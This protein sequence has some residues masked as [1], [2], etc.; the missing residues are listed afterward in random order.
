MKKIGFTLAEVLITLGI[1]GVV[2]ALTIPT[3]VNN[4]QK[5]TYVTGLQRAYAQL[6]Q[7]FKLAMAQDSVDLLQNTNLIKSIKSDI[8]L[9]DYDQKEFVSELGKYIKIQKV[10]YG[11]DFSNGCHDIEYIDITEDPNT[12]TN[13]GGDL[14]IFMADGMI[15]YFNYLRKTSTFFNKNRCDYIKANGGSLCSNNGYIRVDVNGKKGPNKEGR[16]FFAFEIDGYGKVYPYG[17]TS[18]YGRESNWEHSGC[19]GNEIYYGGFACAG[20]I[21]DQGWKMDY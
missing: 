6:Q 9:N 1:I 10:C 17:A 2:A 13:R 5:K 15:Y 4:Y 21:F 18:T 14:Q 3:L 11:M 12:K 19:S 16:D 8:L 20:R 7:V